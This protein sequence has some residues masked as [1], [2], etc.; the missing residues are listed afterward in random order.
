MAMTNIPKKQKKQPTINT[1]TTKNIQ[2][3]D[4]CSMLHLLQKCP[5]IMEMFFIP[6]S[7]W[8]PTKQDQE[9]DC[10]NLPIF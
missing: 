8:Y 9:N 1:K 10:L 3:I 5:D 4:I 6:S 7:Y 2:N